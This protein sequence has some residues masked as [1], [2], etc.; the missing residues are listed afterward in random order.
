M[1]LPTCGRFS[2]GLISWCLPC[3]CHTLFFVS[4][5]FILVLFNTLRFSGWLYPEAWSGFSFTEKFFPHWS[6]FVSHFA[7]FN[8]LQ[9][10]PSGEK[11]VNHYLKWFGGGKKCQQKINFKIKKKKLFYKE[12]TD[13]SNKHY[14]KQIGKELMMPNKS[15]YYS[16]EKKLFDLNQ[17][18]LNKLF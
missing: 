13:N 5:I 1:G 8:I 9:L 18:K 4:I 14:R 11:I 7:K 15:I 12:L 10:L 3:F 2:G 17:K 6:T 16:E